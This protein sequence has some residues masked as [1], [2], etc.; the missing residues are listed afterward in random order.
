MA[1]PAKVKFYPPLE[2]KVNIISHAVGTIFSVVFSIIMIVRAIRYEKLIPV[3]SVIIFGV[4]MIILFAASTA[5][6]S[7]R[8]PALRR[9]LRIIDHGSIYVLIAGS[10]TPFALITL[11]GTLGWVV[12]AVAWALALTG[13]IL[14]LF[15][16]G[17]FNLLS[18]IMYVVMGWLGLLLIKPL[19]NS[20]PIEGLVWLL[21]GGAAYTVGAILYSIK[22]VKF[23]HA[24][25]HLCV[26]AGSSCHAVAVYCYVL[27]SV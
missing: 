19:A 17:R 24:I 7:A 12:F 5:Y 21:S 1:E 3:I 16:T 6:H 4:S 15:F 20:L 26:L 14:K 8:T 23:N 25:F 2:E 10:F 18:T 11:Q 13:I 27:A 22:K 9:K